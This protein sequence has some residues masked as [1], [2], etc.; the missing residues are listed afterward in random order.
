MKVAIIP[1]GRRNHV[2]H[3]QMTETYF[4]HY[5]NNRKFALGAIKVENL[6]IFEKFKMEQ[7]IYYRNSSYLSSHLFKQNSELDVTFKGSYYN[8][9]PYNAMKKLT[10][11][12]ITVCMF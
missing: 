12:F 8:L 6:T 2:L 9:K 4:E 3:F 5:S 10:R 11:D 7:K 1:I